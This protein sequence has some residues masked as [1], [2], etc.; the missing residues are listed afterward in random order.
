MFNLFSKSFDP[1]TDLVDLT[2]KV[3]IVTGGKLSPV[4]LVIGYG[5]VKHL[6]RKGA[7]VYLGA[8]NEQRGKDAIERLKKDDISPG[9]VIW[10]PCDIT[11]P[12]LTKTAAEEFLN[13]EDRL[14]VLIHTL[15]FGCL[16]CS[17]TLHLSSHFSVFQFT[18][19][20]LPLLKRTSKEPGTDVRVVTLSSAPHYTNGATT[21]PKLEINTIE[22]YKADYGPNDTFSGNLARYS[23]A[24][25]SVSLCIRRLQRELKSS[26]VPI[27]CMSIHPG[28]VNT[29]AHRLPYPRLAAWLLPLIA[30]NTDVGAYNSCF[31]AASPRFKP[32][33]KVM[34]GTWWSKPWSLLRNDLEESVWRVTEGYLVDTGL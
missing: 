27:I 3:I 22:D 31:A 25:L 1:S 26:G 20:L 30:S 8:H 24:K 16:V 13:L 10:F 19:S 34:E 9:E 18:K 7:K 12:S 33:G 5:T 23:L 15:S 32:V 29:F 17:L 6:A 2:G 14:D 21:N 28:F 11:S 4:G